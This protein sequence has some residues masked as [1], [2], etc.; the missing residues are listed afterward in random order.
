MFGDVVCGVP[1]ERFEEEI[2]AHQARARRDA[3]HRPRRRRAA[4]A[5]PPLPAP[6]TTSR[7]TRASSCGARS[8]PSSTPGR[9]SARSPTGASR[10][11]RTTG[12]PRSTSS[13]WSSATRATTSGSG[14]AFSRDEVTGAP[15][16]ERR[17]PAERPGRGRRVRRAHAARPLRAGR[18]DARRRRPAAG[19]PAQAGAPL[20]GHAG[21]RVHRR[22]GTSVHAADAQRQAPRPGGG[23]LRRR[24]RRRG[25]DDEGGGDRDDRRGLARRAAAPDV[26]T[27]R[28]LR[29]ASRAGWRPRRARPR[30][31]SCSPRRMPWR[32]PRTAAP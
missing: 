10:A 3:R 25:P 29:G 14:V 32:P 7:A 4:R 12:A 20:Q 5:D 17:L 27:R 16:P 23:A 18:L 15:E 2:A 11:F 26:R 24:R 22:G 9:A 31:R 30:A 6:S 21:H 13:R 8:A 28:P 19:D 1:G